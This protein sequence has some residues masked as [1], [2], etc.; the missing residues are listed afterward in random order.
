MW[1]LLLGMSLTHISHS[2]PLI[3]IPQIPQ[4]TSLS[5]LLSPVSTFSSPTHFL[6]IIKLIQYKWKKQFLMTDLLCDSYNRRW[7]T[8]VDLVDGFGLI[9][10]A[11]TF[12]NLW[13]LF[14]HFIWLSWHYSKKQGGNPRNYQRGFE[15][16][17]VVF[18]KF[19]IKWFDWLSL[20]NWLR[21]FTTLILIIL[22]NFFFL[23]FFCIFCG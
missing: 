18:V 9:G 17:N 13:D 2:L 20:E 23:F 8:Q 19:E 3:H 16:F 5:L 12:F 15:E 6:Y 10:I 21:G 14:C 1:L 7:S 4:N 22:V 11:Q